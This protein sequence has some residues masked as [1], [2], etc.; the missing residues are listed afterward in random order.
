[1]K[2]RWIY[3]QHGEPFEVGA[4]YIPEP[5]GPMIFGDLPEYV[6]PVT[7]LVVSGRVQRREDLKRSGSRPWEGLE[8]EKREARKQ[9]AYSE[10]RLDASLAKAAAESFYQLS[11]SKRDILKRI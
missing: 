2:R 7:G 3:P 6:S 4:D 5:R 1:M 9:Q 10:A 11:P 8:V